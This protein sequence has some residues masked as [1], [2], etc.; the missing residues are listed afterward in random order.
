M[1]EYDVKGIATI[2]VEAGGITSSIAKFLTTE[3]L[4]NI[5][6]K[7]EAKEGDIILIVAH[8]RKIVQNSLGSLRLK[9]AEELKLINENEFNL[10]WVLD[11][12]LFEY[13]DEAKRYVA[14]HHPFTSP[15]DSDLEK[16]DSDPASVYAKAY[17]L[18]L[19]GNEIGGGSIRIH[20][21][22]IQNKM[23]D[24]LN[25]SQEERE[26]K[27]GFLLKA[28]EYGV[29]PHGGIALGF[30]RLTALLTGRKSIRDVIAFPKTNSAVSLMDHAPS[31]V[32]QRQLRELHIGIIN[33]N[34]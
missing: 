14:M 25:L 18:V 12:P 7:V 33:E 20:K 17:D 13:D 24:A 6:Q 19:N 2:K 16:M 3:T 22:D 31:G 8:R 15:M 1:K 23:F 28:F 34:K 30:D 5:A 27:F 21:K 29:P 26:L 11:F 32:D 4:S 10:L 9:L